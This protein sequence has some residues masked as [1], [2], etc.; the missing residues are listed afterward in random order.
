MFIIIKIKFML[1]FDIMIHVCIHHLTDGNVEL[2]C[3][4]SYVLVAYICTLCVVYEGK[5]EFV[6]HRF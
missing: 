1:I 6:E 4:M 3:C 2:V 5:F